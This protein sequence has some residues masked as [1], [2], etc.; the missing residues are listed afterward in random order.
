MKAPAKIPA[1]AH[2]AATPQIVEALRDLVAAGEAPTARQ[3]SA[4]QA[5]I[6]EAKEGVVG[7]LLQDLAYDL[8]YDPVA[9]PDGALGEIA[10]AL[11]AIEAATCA[12]S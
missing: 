8:A 11:R 7:E 5:L 1:P 12:A 4:L 10:R 2:A 6:W 9:A 3:I